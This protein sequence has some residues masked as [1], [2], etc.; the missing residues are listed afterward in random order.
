MIA[1]PKTTVYGNDFRNFY[2]RQTVDIKSQRLHDYENDRIIRLFLK[3]V[4]DRLINNPAGVHI[5]RIGYFY[6]HMIPFNLLWNYKGQKVH[7]YHPCFVPT[8]NSVFKFW[9]MDFHFT[10]S[11][12]KSIRD[13]LKNGH[14][15][16]N[17][18]KGVTVVDHFYLGANHYS[19]KQYKR[20]KKNEI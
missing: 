9:T 4:R 17:M 14:R 19:W 3:K 11:L 1:R 7:K 15:Y 2:K 6:V 12:V 18:I 13:R 16:L 10:R 8:D 5:K 20:I